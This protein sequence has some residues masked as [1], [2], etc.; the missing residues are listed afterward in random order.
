MANPSSGS[1]PADDRTAKAKLRDAAIELVAEEGTS[2][3][4]ARKVAGRAGLSAGLVA[5]HY[6]SMQQLRAAADSHVASVIRHLKTTTVGAGASINVLASAYTPG[7][8]PLV[9]Y[10]ARRLS[11][12]SPEVADLVDEMIDDAVDYLGA[13][14]E[15]GHITSADNPRDRAAVLVLS[16]LGTLVMNDHLKRVLETDLASPDPS[17]SPGFGRYF[18]AILGFYSDGLLTPDYA[19]QLR[20]SLPA[21]AE[22]ASE[23][24]R[25][26]ATA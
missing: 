24:P 26:R 16:Q 4:T 22:S 5:H 3:L 19:R 6:G 8:G 2:I 17:S 21:A 25:R 13:G 14:M 1:G 23:P 20:S 9:G 10:V 12:P 11:D 18:E 15:A 7:Y